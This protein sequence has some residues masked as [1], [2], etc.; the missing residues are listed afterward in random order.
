M[1]VPTFPLGDMTVMGEPGQLPVR[2]WKALA[3]ISLRAHPAYDEVSGFPPGT[4]RD[5]C[6]FMS[7]AVRDFLV[8]IGFE[9][10]TVRGCALY[11]R[12]DD[13]DGEE[14]WSLGIGIPG[15]PDEEDKFNGHAVVT[16]PSLKLLID[17]TMYQAMRPHWLDAISG[18]AALPYHEPWHNQ[19]I[20]QRPT[21][22][23]I[24][25]TYPDRTMMAAWLDRP[26]LPWRKADDFRVRNGR[27][28]AVTKAMREAF[29]GQQ[30]TGPG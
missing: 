18:M 10:A 4:S 7:L 3:A 22:A 1:T 23:G 2:M 14:I 12:A 24:E 20:H 16:V 26:E 8:Q 30:K 21:I 25:M 28:L 9:D 13:N 15:L 27:R 5:K 6:L 11:M 19:L 17:T 29:A